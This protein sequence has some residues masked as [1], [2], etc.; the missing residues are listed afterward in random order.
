MRGQTLKQESV[1][2]N[3]ITV[4][5]GPE[6]DFSTKEINAALIE[7][8]KEYSINQ[9]EIREIEVGHKNGPI[10]LSEIYDPDGKGSALYTLRIELDGKKL[11]APEIN[12]FD[13]ERYLGKYVGVGKANCGTMEETQLVNVCSVKNKIARAVIRIPKKK[14]S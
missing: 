5:I 9:F 6:G 7:L 2:H 14:K 13:Q 10:I 11:Y 12:Q 1:A 8:A 3:N 4:L